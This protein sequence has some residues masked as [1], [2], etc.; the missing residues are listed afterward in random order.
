MNEPSQKLATVHEV[1]AQ[2]PARLIELAITQN[3]DVEKL[4][5]LMQLQ[6]RW[7]KKQAEKAFYDALSRFQSVCPTINKAKK[8]SYNK[9][10]YTYATLDD[11]VKAIREPLKQ[12]GLTYRWE[13]SEPDGAIHI[14][15]VITHV[16][17]HS[18]RNGM[19]ALPD[20]SGAKNEIQQR[21]SAVTYL[22]RYTL[23]GALGITSADTD[24]DGKASGALN[25]ERM[26]DHMNCVKEHWESIV[27]MKEWIGTDQ[28]VQVAEAWDEISD[29]DKKR[30]WLAPTKGGIFT[31]KEREYFRSEQFISALASLKNGN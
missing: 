6:E 11:V 28:P 12:C 2:S 23:I 24:D 30:L 16:N 3:A 15:C 14:D 8:V 26:L 9:T 5:R 7:D 27:A 21:G 22:Q 18:E 10:E 31:T 1:S 13:Q 25:V 29:D 19:T 17:G 4:E 20:N